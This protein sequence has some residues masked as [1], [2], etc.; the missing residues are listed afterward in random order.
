MSQKLNPTQDAFL[1]RFINE[2]GLTEKGAGYQAL[3]TA[4]HNKPELTENL[5]S[6]QMDILSVLGTLETGGGN[7]ELGRA[8]D[9]AMRN[10]LDPE[11]FSVDE[12]V[13]SPYGETTAYTMSGETK[14]GE[15]RKVVDFGYGIPKK[16]N[17][18]IAL[19]TL[20]S[21]L[22]N[23]PEFSDTTT[24]Q[25]YDKLMTDLKGPGKIMQFVDYIKNLNK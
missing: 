6:E 19:E 9:Y 23:N 15:K 4:I 11:S 1:E 8:I 18:R 25:E 12:G 2:A 5:A 21:K 14:G 3:L 10:E 7:E 24:T 20:Q 22:E 17:R 13:M 16:D